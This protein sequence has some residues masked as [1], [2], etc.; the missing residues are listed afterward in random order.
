ME[1]TTIYPGSIG[2]I[3]QGKL[4][5]KDVLLSCP[6][7]LF[8]KVRLFESSKPVNIFENP[9]CYNFLRNIAEEWGM[10]DYAAHM[11]IEI[12]TEIPK[13]KGFASSTADLCALYYSMLKLF[14]KK[15]NEEELI[16]GCLKIE[17][18][19]SIIFKKMTVFDYKKGSFYKEIGEYIE[20][21][22]LVFEGENVIDT[23]E[24]NKKIL[25][26]QSGIE[27]I[28][29]ILKE[30]IAKKDINTIAFAATESILRNQ[31]R[32][33]YDILPE[34]I[35]IKNITGGLGIVGAHSGD[36]LGIIYDDEE[37]LDK[38]VECHFSTGKYKI[39]KLSTL[40]WQRDALK[41][42]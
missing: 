10:E 21:H 33:K 18:T 28:L 27:D 1:A 14:N 6:V 17:P 32:L 29:E 38:A 15:F 5:G 37:R 40:K 3:I 22:L 42:T 26:E 31:H 24:F 11:D 39:Y 20:F 30:G 12:F 23:V 8:T 19:D 36:A 4:Q 41:A 35:R 2:E 13:G 7:N 16:K 34:I 25:P 9:K